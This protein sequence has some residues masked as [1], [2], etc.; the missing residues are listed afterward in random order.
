MEQ[1]I[2]WMQAVG[3]GG[4]GRAKRRVWAGNL[5]PKQSGTKRQKLQDSQMGSE[6][7]LQK[8]FRYLA[9]G[10]CCFFFLVWLLRKE[11]PVAS[12][13]TWLPFLEWDSAEVWCWVR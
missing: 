1:H 8:G 4:F 6:D 9:R 3:P 5:F 10:S 2:N 12:L 7:L 13:H 11:Y